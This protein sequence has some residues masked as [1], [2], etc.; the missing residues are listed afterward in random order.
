MMKL[1]S[2]VTL[3]LPNCHELIRRQALPIDEMYSWTQEFFFQETSALKWEE[4]P[5]E[6]AWE[7]CPKWDARNRRLYCN[8]SIQQAPPRRVHTKIIGMPS[9]TSLSFEVA[10]VFLLSMNSWLPLPELHSL[11]IKIASLLIPPYPAAPWERR[12]SLMLRSNQ[13]I[14]MLLRE[15]EHV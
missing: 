3:P 14:C 9:S 8:G 13:C 4:Y 1:L 11:Y 2:T 6:R 7:E 12:T 5:P 10:A 15:C